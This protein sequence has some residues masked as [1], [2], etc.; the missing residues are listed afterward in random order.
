MQYRI[1]LFPT[2]GKSEYNCS[3]VEQGYY[4]KFKGLCVDDENKSLDDAF[5][6]ALGIELPPMQ[7]I[8]TLRQLS[9]QSLR[10]FARDCK[11][12][13]TQLNNLMKRE[14]PSMNKWMRTL[15]L[16]RRAS[17]LSWS[18]LGK[19]WDDI[20]LTDDEKSGKK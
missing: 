6:E 12:D 4:I 20:Y 8:E 9:G 7:W 17:G 3:Q 2:Q 16:M 19:L 1:Q 13:H 14:S 18:R 15:C 5:C 11:T 10:A